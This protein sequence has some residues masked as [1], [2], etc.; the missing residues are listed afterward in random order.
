MKKI[1]LLFGG[2]STEHYI[3]CLSAKTII[4]NID[5]SKYE[6]TTVGIDNENHWYVF[7]DDLSFLEK[8]AWKESENI[9]LISNVVNYLSLFDVVFPITHGN[10]G[11]D[12]KLQG[13]LDFFG[14]K[15][16]GCKTLASAVGMDKKIAK[17][18]F[19]ELKIPQV[20]Y[21]T[22]TFPK[23]S[24]K[25]II[26]DLGFPVIVKPANGGSSIGISKARN[27]KELVDSILEAS[28][29]DKKIIIE[30]FITARELECSVLEDKK[31]LVSSIGEI[32]SANEFYDY[33]AKYESEESKTIIPAILPKKISN[34][35]KDIA[36]LAFTGIDGSGYARVDFFYD[37]E[38]NQIY[39]NEI[40]TIPGFTNISM[41]PK[42]LMFDSI[43]LPEIIT[44][45]IENA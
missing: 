6:L 7:D 4:E 31:L 3:S 1:L 20:P 44:I 26:K 30:K 22:F 24:F 37:E 40:N 42:L 17:M 2:N 5:K 10:N 18:I 19:N 35:I 27:K 45:L 38:N 28:S 36:K 8:G 25:K 43:S 15:Y 14:I 12:G 11:E 29:Y 39:L 41:F 33:S 21:L 13:F 23:Y 9:H 16:V 32:I 34:T